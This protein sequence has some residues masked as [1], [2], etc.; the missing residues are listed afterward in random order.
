MN[1]KLH[2]FIYFLSTTSLIFIFSTAIAGVTTP[3][4][5]SSDFL[6]FKEPETNLSKIKSPLTHAINYKCGNNDHAHKLAQLIQANNNQQR[7]ELACNPKLNEIALIKANLM[8]QKQ[9]VWH[10][11]G[12]MSPNQLLRHHGFKLPKTYPFFG[13]QVEAIAGGK[14][15]PETLFKDFVNSTPHRMLLLGENEFFK[16]QNQMGVAYIKDLSTDHQHY[17]VVIIAATHSNQ[18][19]KTE[20]V[21]GTGDFLPE[22]VESNNRKRLRAM[23][24]RMYQ[25]KVKDRWK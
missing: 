3:V 12:N 18:N 20:H 22:P 14:D 13:N 4:S 8:L 1:N 19:I 5:A 11:V 23:K 15:S 25:N 2:Q 24:K 16:N 10:N 6:K 21:V 7:K 9:N 17:W